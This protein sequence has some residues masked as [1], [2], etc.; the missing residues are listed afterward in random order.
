[1][2]FKTLEMVGFKSFATKTTIEFFPGTTIVV[3]P[4]GCGK[5]NI[6]DA[7]RWVLGEQSAKSLRANRMADVIFNG[8]SSYKPLGFAQVALTFSNED[9]SLP[10][11][12]SEIVVTRRLFR[13]GESEYLLNKVPCRLKDI[14]ELLMGTGIGMDAYSIMEQG[15]VDLIINAKPSERRYIFEEAAGIAKY[16]LRKEEALRKLVRTDED[17]LRLTDIIAEVKRNSISLKRQATRAERYKEFIEEQRTLEMQLLALRYQSYRDTRTRV[18][19]SYCEVNDKLQGLNARIAQ[20]SAESEELQEKTG[21]LAQQL[22]ET[23]AQHFSVASDIEKAEHRI[24]L[25][26]ERIGH[27]DE[28]ARRL[29][30]ERSQCEAECQTIGQALRG[31]R[32]E[33]HAVEHEIQEREQMH[34]AIQTSLLAL[35][36][37]LERHE[38]TISSQS[39]RQE[40]LREQ[41][42]HEDNARSLAAAVMQQL[43]GQIAALRHSQA[44]LQHELLG[45]EGERAANEARLQEVGHSI[46][47][48]R[49]KLEATKGEIAGKERDLSHL[50]QKIEVASAHVRELE[51]RL[52]V[53]QELEA[54][55]EG[56]GQSVR[57]LMEAAAEAR[58]TGIV[59]VVA[60]VVSTE[61][62]YE[63]AIEAA[64]GEALQA[65]IAASAETAGHAL[66]YLKEQNKGRALVYPLDRIPSRDG[67]GTIEILLG[68]EGVIGIGSKLVSCDQQFEPLVSRLLGNTLVVRD[69]SCVS[70]LEEEKNG[71]QFVTLDG[72]VLRSDGGMVGGKAQ[73]GGLLGRERE[74]KEL[75]RALTASRGELEELHR[76]QEQEEGVLGTYEQEQ[77]RVV[78][79]L[80]ERE[81]EHAQ[82]AKDVEMIVAVC[83]E[84][85]KL[86][87]QS[88]EKEA[89]L[90]VERARLAQESS[91]RTAT[92]GSLDAE[93]QQGAEEIAALE[94]EVEH[95]KTEMEKASAQLSALL[96]AIASRRERIQ[97]L[98]DKE[99]A[100]VQEQEALAKDA[101]QKRSSLAVL[102]NEKQLLE[103]EIH[104]TEHELQQ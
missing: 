48:L 72:T 100:L 75:E 13:T 93:I 102:A 47:A 18:E 2:L 62:A 96:V 8:S 65:V 103:Q 56:Y 49:Q 64:L 43:D 1:M 78:R 36:A 17:L 57:V 88:E 71:A 24:S 84:K 28:Q 34:E 20:C 52:K 76:L 30:E 38:A 42:A 60:K 91:A 6:F 31:V 98:R 87:G 90:H 50:D 41:R 26:K 99:Q 29:E 77:E 80:R 51:S 46:D 83:D 101:E 59:G 35:K 66:S 25:F 92:I 82:L 104:R 11:D 68:E 73:V 16:K 23:Q 55:Y 15:K 58:L 21:Q 70:R 27:L 3:G 67:N 9:R 37:Q 39:K 40:E 95:A 33:R 89:E 97:A 32:E 54:S 22:A 45:L 7:I 5:S 94:R 61:Q 85:R 86:L 74:I 69:V 19:Q 12:F 79:E 4:N 81:I 14:V 44:S 63:A 10:I 53:L